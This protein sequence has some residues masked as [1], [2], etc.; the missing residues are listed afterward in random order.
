MVK[1]N[2]TFEQLMLLIY[3]NQ[4]D[5]GND[6]FSWHGTDNIIYVC[7]P[8][9]MNQMPADFFEKSNVFNLWRKEK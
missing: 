8:A 3:T 5:S 4:L 9:T 1:S 7:T 2:L 6:Y